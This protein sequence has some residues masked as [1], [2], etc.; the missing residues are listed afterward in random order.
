[1]TNEIRAIAML[2]I[3]AAGMVVV[4]TAMIVMGYV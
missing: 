3:M 4:L 2:L 1:M